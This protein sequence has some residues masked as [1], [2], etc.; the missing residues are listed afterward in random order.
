VFRL[1]VRSKGIV[2]CGIIFEMISSSV[3]TAL[4]PTTCNL[5]SWKR[6]SKLLTSYI[7][8]V[9]HGHLYHTLGSTRSA[10]PLNS[11][12]CLRPLD[13]SKVL[14]QSYSSKTKQDEKKTSKGKIFL[15]VVG[16]GVGALAGLGYVF[17][18]MNH[19]VMPIANIDGN[20][21]AFLFS[22]PPPIDMI[23][24]RVVNPDDD[25]GLKVTL[26]QYQACPFCTKVRAFLDFAGVSYDV[27]EVNPV[28]KKQVGWS[29]YKKVPTVVV[30]VKEGYQ[31]HLSTE[32][33][34]NQTYLT[35]LCAAAIKRQQYDNIFVGI[36]ST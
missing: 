25:S 33:F 17:R 22:E 4:R 27:I 10:V 2:R 16:F 26:F 32:C 13:S 30:Q 28:T 14:A 11:L 18:K 23:A 19:K 15:A 21:N 31:V 3:V 9:E 34:T 7:K 8:A 29:V 1:L 24:R 36:L 12:T 6:S 5:T 35:F 20:G